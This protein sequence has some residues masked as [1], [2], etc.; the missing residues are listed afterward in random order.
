MC[1]IRYNFDAA[2]HRTRRRNVF[3]VEVLQGSVVS[4]DAASGCGAHA[5]LEAVGIE[6]AVHIA[7]EET[8]LELLQL[9]GVC[10]SVELYLDLDPGK[11]VF[12]RSQLLYAV[13]Y[14][15]DV[16]PVFMMLNENEQLRAGSPFIRRL[17][18]KHRSRWRAMTLPFAPS[19]NPS[20]ESVTR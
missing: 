4:S 8:G 11:A 10:E 1:L 6:V 9:T 19:C 5:Q 12:R 18:N 2:V 3:A 13:L 15:D 17:R 7:F 20:L 14:R 16:P